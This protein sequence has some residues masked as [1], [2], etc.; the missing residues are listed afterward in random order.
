MTVIG[1]CWYNHDYLFCSGR[2]E[3][4]SKVSS[5]EKIVCGSAVAYCILSGSGTHP[6]MKWVKTKSV[7]GRENGRGEVIRT[8]VQCWWVCAL[9][10]VPIQ[11]KKQRIE[12]KGRVTVK[13]KREGMTQMSV[14]PTTKKKIFFWVR[15][16]AADYYYDV[17]Y[18]KNYSSWCV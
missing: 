1:L 12:S 3:W 7:F 9:L 13:G 17:C 15:K 11:W 10:H 14:V 16:E 8:R 6:T 18:Y 2:R 5:S 4:V